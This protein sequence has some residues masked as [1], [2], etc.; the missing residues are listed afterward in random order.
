MLV[1]QRV[2][3]LYDLS[4]LFM[5]Q[6][7]QEYKMWNLGFGPFHLISRTAP[8]NFGVG[9]EYQVRG[10]QSKRA[11]PALNRSAIATSAWGGLHVQ[12]GGKFQSLDST[13]VE[14]RKTSIIIRCHKS[15]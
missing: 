6:P 14:G 11:S 3:N 2:F 8:S 9:S 4:H 15:N 1:H 12:L 7:F 5:D 13:L 10:D